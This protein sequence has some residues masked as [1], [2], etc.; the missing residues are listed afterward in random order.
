M[1]QDTIKRIEKN[2]YSDILE[3]SDIEF[4]KK[5]WFGL[6]A[7]YVSSYAEVMCRLFDDHQYELFVKKYTYQ[8]NYISSFREQLEI[9]KNKLISFNKEENK[10]DIEIVNDI[11]WIKISQLA[12][13]IINEWKNNFPATMDI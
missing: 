1:N 3:I 5:V 2:I 4:Q 13:S 10:S 6:Q 7:N 8:L 11:E 12:K 9:L